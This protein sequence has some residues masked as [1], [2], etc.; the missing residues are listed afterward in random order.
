MTLDIHR[1]RGTPRRRRRHHPPLQD[2]PGRRR[3]SGR[4]PLR[5]QPRHLPPAQPPRVARPCRHHR[6]AAVPPARPAWQDRDLE[7]CKRPCQG[8]SRRT[9]GDSGGA[10]AES[11]STSRHAGQPR[12]GLILETRH[13][14]RGWQFEPACET[15]QAQGGPQS[16]DFPG[17]A[18][19]R[20]VPA[21]SE[22]VRIDLPAAWALAHDHPHKSG[23][24]DHRHNQAC[25]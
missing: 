24:Q 16:A 13:G 22:C 8:L 10:S 5:L 3:P 25:A 2:R 9:V 23:R 11:G 15:P 18:P 6:R 1:P 7:A 20:A 17:L 4:H 21:M 14:T 12:P 19:G